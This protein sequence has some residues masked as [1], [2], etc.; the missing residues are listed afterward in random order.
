MCY[1]LLIRHQL[2]LLARNGDDVITLSTELSKT[3]MRWAEIKQRP[4]VCNSFSALL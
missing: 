4:L 3:P 1:K 2:L